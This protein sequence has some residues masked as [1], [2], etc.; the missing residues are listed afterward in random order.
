VLIDQRPEV[1]AQKARLGDWEAD[2][3]IGRNHQAAIVSLVERQSKLTRLAKV[4]RNTAQL[5]THAVT[6]QLQP[7][8][9]KTITS[10]N[11]LP[12]KASLR[13]RHSSPVRGGSCS[14]VIFYRS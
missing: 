1:V 2:T 13:Q 6:A 4:A 11:V 5:V 7:L 3:I 12:A 9:V 14:Q 10:D 8:V